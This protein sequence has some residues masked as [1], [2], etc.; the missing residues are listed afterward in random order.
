MKTIRFL[1]GMVLIGL[2]FS[3][4]G[5]AADDG[6]SAI[7]LP[8]VVNPGKT[9]LPLVRAVLPF[10]C[11]HVTEIQTLECAALKALYESTDGP[12]WYDNDG[13]LDTPYPCS[14]SGVGCINGHVTRLDWGG[15][16]RFGCYYP[17]NNLAGPLPPELG[18]LGYLETLALPDNA[19]TGP[20]PPELGNLTELRTLDLT[21][22]QLEESI[23]PEL[24]NLG[25]LWTLALSGNALTGP[26]PKE[27]GN[28]GN[29]SYLALDDNA[30]TGPIPKE[31][32]N[33]DQ[34]VVYCL[35]SDNRLD[36]SIPKELGNL[37]E[38]RTLDTD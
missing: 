22:N 34:V 2:V 1:V 37:T 20:I 11:E 26:I 36:G 31:L 24:D 23:P 14:W 16:S 32:G 4:S 38:L 30:L 18:N 17:P 5:V 25:N 28:L 10:S 15:C 12:N 9:Y 33:L 29:V 8:Y 19:L 3:F 13:W 7:Y 27:L 35:M 6:G 21:N